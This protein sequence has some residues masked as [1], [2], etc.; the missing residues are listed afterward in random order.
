MKLLLLTGFLENPLKNVQEWLT[1]GF[2]WFLD[3]SIEVLLPISMIALFLYVAGQKQFKKYVSLPC[4]IYFLLQC[5][6]VVM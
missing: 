4:L 3:N 1:T 6:K 2:L 5:L